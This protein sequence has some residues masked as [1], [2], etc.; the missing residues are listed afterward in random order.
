MAQLSWG[1]P[2]IEFG[3][4]GANGAAPTTWTKLAFDPVENSTKLTPTKGEKKEAKVEGGENEAVKYAKNTYVFEFEVRA[5]K[6][7]VKPIEDADGVVEGEYAVR[8]TPEDATVEGILI[9]K[10]TVSVEETFDTAEGKKWKYT[11]DV[12]KP[13]EGN[14]VKP[15]MAPAS[16]ED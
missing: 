1:K 7:R 12:L 6:G 15:Y 4:C 8:L 3:K 2:T 16:S 13:A 11:F 14:Q 10:A 9:D 5:A